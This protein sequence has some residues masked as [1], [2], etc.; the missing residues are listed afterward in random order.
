MSKEK[1]A[2]RLCALDEIAR[3]L[4]FRQGMG[5]A[6]ARAIRPDLVAVE[7]DPEA[8]QQLLHFAADWARRW[9]PLAGLD[10]VDG[11]M[12]DISGCAHLFDGEAGMLAAITTAY[13]RQGLR[14]EAAIAATPAL[15]RAL[16]RL[17][18]NL[19]LPPG[20]ERRAA[21]PLPVHHLCLDPEIHH[22]LED[23]GLKRI[24]D[25]LIRPRSALAARFGKGLI[26][27]LDEICAT[28][29]PSPIQPRFPL[30]SYMAEKRFFEPI[31]REEDVSAACLCLAGE[32][33]KALERHGEGGRSFEFSLFRTDG[34][35]RRL[36]VASGAPLRDP[37]AIARLFK[38]RFTAAADALDPGFGFDVLRLSA[39]SVERA[40]AAQISL[41]EA[42][43]ETA[44]IESAMGDL[45]DRLGARLGPGKVTRF[46][47]QDAHLPEESFVALPAARGPSRRASA[48]PTG[49]L[50]EE[51]PH[52]PARLFERPEPVEAVAAV[53][54]GAPLRFRWRRALHQVMAAEGPERIAPPWWRGEPGL[55]RDYFR[56][57]DREGRRFWLYREGV[58][59]RETVE[60]RWFMHGLCA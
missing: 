29:P 54:D 24:G 50:P 57:E 7:A 18:R 30:P 46:E 13:E 6:D 38:E 59:G 23:A 25:V 26:D 47:P 33:A 44:R 42:A 3:A 60:A 1:G 2:L 52:R 14:A 20:G 31:G 11:L 45:V 28:A 32:L 10:G 41:D 51:A 15:A 4:G 48:W 8:E 34:V 56:V 5:L 37:Q 27:R 19:V 55:A 35:S 53:P 21:E 49:M 36:V 22:G 17:G 16:A 9:T 12:L 58:Y 43:M 40:A 39:L